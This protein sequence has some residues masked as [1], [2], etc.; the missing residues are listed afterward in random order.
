[1]SQDFF[2]SIAQYLP[3]IGL[4]IIV[5][6]I[7][8]VPQKRRDKKVREMLNSIKVGDNI[9]T[10]GGIYGKVAK[11]KEDLV[12]IQTGPDKVQI[13]ISKSAIS[14]VDYSDVTQ[15]PLA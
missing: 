14:S 6:I 4:L 2:K 12:T 10:I 9:R 8:I 3:M 15:D 11:L 1:M 5:S 7:M 13:L